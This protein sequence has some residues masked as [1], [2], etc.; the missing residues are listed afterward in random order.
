MKILCWIAF[1]LLAS[2]PLTAQEEF[3]G[4]EDAR[5]AC[6]P[7]LRYQPG[8]AGRPTEA[9]RKAFEREKNCFGHFYDPDGKPEYDKARRCCLVRGD[10]NRELAMI[11]AN[12]WGTPRDL[13]AATY[14]LCRTGEEMAPA[15][16]WSMLQ[17]VD[18]LRSGKEK[19]NLDY[20]EH[21]TSG[22]GASWCVGLDFDKRHVEWERRA[23]A[24]ERT[25]APEA[26]PAFAALRKAADTLAQ[27]DA[28]YM[29]EPN[30]GGTIY[31]S[32]ALSSRIERNDDLLG[33][34]ERCVQK[35]VPAATPDALKKADAALNAAYKAILAQAK[36]DDKEYET[37]TAG[38]DVLREAQRAWIPYRDAWI[39]FYRLR[40]KGAA[41][42]EEL[43]REI[44]AAITQQRTRD[45]NEL[46]AEP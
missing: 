36:A 14:F 5:K 2:L 28:E 6:E 26:R 32:V 1:T 11:F 45:L 21:V 19:G 22:M 43:D 39:A 37:G 8:P 34:L 16:Q 40:W 25:L 23:A 41:P 27:E 44:A 3:W 7:F 20:C 15:E 13:G 42:A 35:R 4:E 33:T 12:G 30:R 24:I 31:P 17:F 10:C 46:G 38:Q 29:A 9:D 18:D